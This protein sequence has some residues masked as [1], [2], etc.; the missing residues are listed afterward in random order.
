MEITLEIVLYSIYSI[1][2]Y[3]SLS[4][5]YRVVSIMEIGLEIGLDGTELDR[6][7]IRIEEKKSCGVYF[8]L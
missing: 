4:E 7:E 8:L 2:Y 3:E 6:G 5:C 1:I